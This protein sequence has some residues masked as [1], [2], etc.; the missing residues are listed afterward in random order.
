MGRSLRSRLLLQADHHLHLGLSMVGTCH[1]DRP[2]VCPSV[3]RRVRQHIFGRRDVDSACTYLPQDDRH[4]VCC[5]IDW[6]GFV[7]GARSHR[8][9]RSCQ[10]SSV[11]WVIGFVFSCAS[12]LETPDLR[13]RP[14]A[15][16]IMLEM[17]VSET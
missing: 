6:E 5:D 7:F 17:E 16:L 13:L 14:H 4:C 10:E 1:L 11:D 3:H 15:E 8:L 12:L 2:L 9:C